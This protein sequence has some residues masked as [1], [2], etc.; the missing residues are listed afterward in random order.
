METFIFCTVVQAIGAVLDNKYHWIY[1]YKKQRQG[2]N[3]P[4]KWNENMD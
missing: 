2:N 1:L 4:L 3:L